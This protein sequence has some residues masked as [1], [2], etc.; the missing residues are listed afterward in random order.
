M[1]L[2]QGKKLTSEHWQAGLTSSVH[3]LYARRRKYDKYVFLL[4]L[5]V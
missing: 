4:A 5:S 3:Y 1:V 2:N